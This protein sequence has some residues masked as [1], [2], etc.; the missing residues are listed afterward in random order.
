MAY[1]D[2]W[3]GN[4]GWRRLTE[5]QLTGT[6]LNTLTVTLTGTGATTGTRVAADAVRVEGVADLLVADPATATA[7]S[8]TEPVDFWSARLG[9]NVQREIVVR[10]TGSGHLQ[11]T[12]AEFTRRQMNWMNNTGAFSFA[13]GPNGLA[14][15]SIPPGGYTTLTIRRNSVNG[16]TPLGTG[17]Y[18]GT[19]RLT[20]NDVGTP[21][22]DIGLDGS[23]VLGVTSGVVDNGDPEFSATS[24]WTRTTPAG[25]GQDYHAASGTGQTA[26]WTFGGLHDGTYEVQATWPVVGGAGTGAFGA[27]GQPLRSVP[28]SSPPNDAT[29]YGVAWES[30][31]KVRVTGGRLTVELTPASGTAVA[32]GV[33]VV[34]L[35]N[36]LP[37]APATGRLDT[38]LVDV[39]GEYAVVD[40]TDKGRFTSSSSGGSWMPWTYSSSQAWQNQVTY[41]KTGGPLSAAWSVDAEPGVYEVGVSWEPATNRSTAVSYQVRDAAGGNAAV[42]GGESAAEPGDRHVSD[43]G[44]QA[45]PAVDDGVHGGGVVEVVDGQSDGG[46]GDEHD[47]GGGGRGVRAA[48]RPAGREP[49]DAGRPARGRVSPRRESGL[50]E[51]GPRVRR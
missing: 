48:D 31:G 49:A 50:G 13:D 47:A 3:D 19:V 46:L 11:L 23:V 39:Q 21:A 2:F 20:S 43:G 51:T 41:I 38:V 30:L 15:Q 10:N 36:E 35:D 22:Y 27:N 32:D 40:S 1:V 34:S 28:Q 6:G 24:G 12:N 8:T 45:V 4:L 42:D 26:T 16:D 18:L 29:A 14:A 44:W 25:F 33:R 5:V 17:T 7:Y 37:S 9:E